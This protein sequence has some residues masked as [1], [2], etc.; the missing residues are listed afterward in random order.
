VPQNYRRIAAELLFCGSGKVPQN[1]AAKPPPYKGGGYFAALMF[2]ATFF[3]QPK[4]NKKPFAKKYLPA[5]LSKKH[6]YER[7]PRSG[8]I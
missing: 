3:N 4:K 5:Y 6:K 7:T 8:R 1:Y 2:S